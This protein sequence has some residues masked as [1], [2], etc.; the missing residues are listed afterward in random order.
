MSRA[1]SVLLKIDGFM[2][3]KQEK[4]KSVQRIN[5]IHID[6][7]RRTDAYMRTYQI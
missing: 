2:R 3:R 5:Q 7:G 6:F 4:G 1:K